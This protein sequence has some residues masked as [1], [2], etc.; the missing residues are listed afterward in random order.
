V[1]EAFLLAVVKM[2]GQGN[3][4]GWLFQVVDNLCT[5]HQRKTL[6]RA[7]LAAKWGTAPIPESEFDQEADD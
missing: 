2:R 5:N 4:R 3:P 1:Q 6:R 7:R